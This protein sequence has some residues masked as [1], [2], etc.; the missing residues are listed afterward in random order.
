MPLK[1]RT[2]E[3]KEARQVAKQAAAEDAQR[4][5]ET[6][7]R[8][9]QREA[10]LATPPGQARTAFEQGDELFQT[11]SSVMSQQA[12]IMAMIGSTTKQKANDPTVIL[13]AICREG[14]ELVNGSFVFVEQGQESRD[15]FLAS[16]QNVAI[17]GTTVGYYLFR[18]CE[19]NK[20]DVRLPWEQV[21]EM[22]ESAGTIEMQS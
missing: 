21:P 18:R 14:W 19:A 22:A 1:R 10:Y 9:R 2:T 7:E 8:E 15:K 5:R 6:K 3:E 20:R 12:I 11:E 17:K 4:E 16:G 13:N